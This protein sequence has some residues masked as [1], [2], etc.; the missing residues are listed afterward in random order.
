MGYPSSVTCIT[1]AHCVKLITNDNG[2]NKAHPGLRELK[3]K[4]SGVS[5]L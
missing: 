5:S 3:L 2:A 4:K 1:A